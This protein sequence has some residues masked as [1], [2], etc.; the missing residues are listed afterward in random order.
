MTPAAS[1]WGRCTPKASGYTNRASRAHRFSAA[2]SSRWQPTVRDR[3]EAAATHRLAKWFFLQ[4]LRRQCAQTLLAERIKCS[5]PDATGAHRLPQRV[6]NLERRPAQPA[7]QLL[8]QRNMPG[9]KLCQCGIMRIRGNNESLSLPPPPVD[10]AGLCALLRA[11][12]AASGA[13]ALL[14][15]AELVL[16]QL[17]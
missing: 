15:A 3:A 8:D 9:R 10:G 4:E 16:T 2:A 17:S 11:V 1:I 12:A 14:R 5:D 7:P 13:G 6:R